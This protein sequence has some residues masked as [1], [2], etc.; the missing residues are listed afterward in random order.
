MCL[1]QNDLKLEICMFDMTFNSGDV[2]WIQRA[3][4]PNGQMLKLCLGRNQ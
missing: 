2:W 3:K 4:V 1:V